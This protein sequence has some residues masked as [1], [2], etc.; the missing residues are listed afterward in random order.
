MA[1]KYS[2]VCVYPCVHIYVH[3]WMN[4]K[5]DVVC[6]CTHTHTYTPH[7]YHSSIDGHRLFSFLGSRGYYAKRNKT[8]G[9]RQIAMTSLTH[10]CN[11]KSKRKDKTKTDL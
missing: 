9:K 7:L 1:G 5:E 6:M 2:S 4:D 8:D 10:M 3:Q 11:I